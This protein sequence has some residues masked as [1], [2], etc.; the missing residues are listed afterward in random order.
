LLQPQSYI[1]AADSA[2][3]FLPFSVNVTPLIVTN[4]GFGTPLAVKEGIVHRLSARSAPESVDSSLRR[5]LVTVSNV[6]LFKAS[7]VLSA[8]FI[9]SGVSPTYS[10][11]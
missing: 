6:L 7:P 1:C 2:G 3:N 8:L 5:Y 4:D 11:E 10:F 9:V